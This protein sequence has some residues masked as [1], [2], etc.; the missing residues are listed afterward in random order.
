ME[1][2][3]WLQSIRTP[4]GDAFF[5]LITH[6][7]EETLFI[8]FG[9]L[10]FWC[11]DKWE[12]YYLL[13]TGLTG[14]V[15][16]QGLKLWFRVPRPWVR[17]PDFPIVEAARAEATGYS[18][19]SGHTQSAVGIFGAL[20]RWNK[21]RWLRIL[22]V[23]LCL[24]VPFS[25]M[26]LGVHTPADVGVS[27]LLALVMVFGFYP[28]IR[29]AMRSPN[30]MR[31]L[32]LCMVA[33]SV[34]LLLF[35]TQYP[36]PADVDVANLEHGAKNAWKMLG[37]MLGVWLTYE[38]DLR[39]T[40]FDTKAPLAGQILK[41]VLGFAILLAIKSGMK[42]PLHALFANDYLAD[43]LRYFLMV[44]FAGCL[45]P[46]TFPTWAKIGKKK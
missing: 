24:L 7:G 14:T 45:W 38:C 44:A 22:C 10:V 43:G 25:R 19:P 46:L 40:K 30:T 5:S 12:G 36:F 33:A 17:D 11:L 9:L 28:V 42:A 31:L 21:Q 20:A 34:G 6:L 39:W 32:L 27:F 29:K 37:C 35:V 18:F 23:A 3:Y 1:L 15:V 13:S 16:N 8:V 4:L 41:L 2:L 26:Y